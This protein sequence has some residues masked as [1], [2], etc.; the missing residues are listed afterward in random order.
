MNWGSL[1]HIWG[2]CMCDFGVFLWSCSAGHNFLHSLSVSYRQNHAQARL[3]FVLSSNCFLMYQSN[4]T[5]VCFQNKCWVLLG[6]EIG[7]R[8]YSENICRVARNLWRMTWWFS[9]CLQYT[10]D[11]ML[12]NQLRNTNGYIFLKAPRKARSRQMTGKKII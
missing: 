10:L 3:K 1:I 9:I 11:F 12:E 4:G 2:V 6:L 8:K 7:S 5:N